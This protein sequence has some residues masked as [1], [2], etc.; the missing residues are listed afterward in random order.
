MT[1]LFFN[2]VQMLSNPHSI[3]QHLPNLCQIVL[4][5][6]TMETLLLKRLLCTW[7]VLSWKADVNL[8]TSV[9]DT[10]VESCLAKVLKWIRAWLNTDERSPLKAEMVEILYLVARDMQK[11]GCKC[12]AMAY[13][14]ELAQLHDFHTKQ[15]AAQNRAVVS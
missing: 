5:A 8:G 10:N 9:L 11:T 2:I 6:G 12:S 4:S 15:C 13:F 7:L 3:L 14:D 1:F